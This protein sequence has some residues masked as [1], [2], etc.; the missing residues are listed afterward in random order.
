M[1]KGHWFWCVGYLPAD[2]EACYVL[3]SHTAH[4]VTPGLPGGTALQEGVPFIHIRKNTGIN[5][6]ISC[7]H[8]HLLT[9]PCAKFALAACSKLLNSSSSFPE[10]TLDMYVSR[11]GFSS[12]NCLKWHTDKMQRQVA[13]LKCINPLLPRNGSHTTE[14]RCEAMQN[15]NDCGCLPDTEL[16]RTVHEPSQISILEPDGMAQN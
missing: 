16:L 8:I 3:Y 1:F 13:A 12:L 5:I 10:G 2:T 4:A 9:I 11:K 15:G 6:A 7:S 14:S